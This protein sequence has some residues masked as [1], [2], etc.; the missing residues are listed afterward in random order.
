MV[1]AEN[2]KGKLQ[3]LGTCSR[4]PDQTLYIEHFMERLS[5]SAAHGKSLAGPAVRSRT[6]FMALFGALRRLAC[7]SS[8]LS[9]A[10]APASR[11]VST[12]SNFST[13]KFAHNSFD[14][15]SDQPALSGVVSI[16]GPLSAAW[17]A[18]RSQGLDP[19]HRLMQIAGLAHS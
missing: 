11:A 13:A 7:S 5:V 14:D 4:E 19:V 6:A 16:H 18:L 12:L 2:E 9:A 1:P 17:Y 15:N 8:E 10:A 3:D